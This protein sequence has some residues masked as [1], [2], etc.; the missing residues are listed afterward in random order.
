M[1]MW[2]FRKS[3]MWR[4]GL[5]AHMLPGSTQ[6]WFPEV[7]L[8]VVGRVECRSGGHSIYSLDLHDQKGVNLV[9]MILSCAILTRRQIG[10]KCLV[11]IW[12]S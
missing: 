1:D 5:R 8:C 3:S 11:I 9:G 6:S 2:E 12:L 7:K 10:I 4:G